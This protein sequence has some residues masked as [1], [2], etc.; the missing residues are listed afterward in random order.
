M[1][2]S[3]HN[4][5][6]NLFNLFIVSILAGLVFGFMR[7]QEAHFLSQLSFNEFEASKH[8]TNTI[9]I[10]I[11]FTILFSIVLIPFYL[12]IKKTKYL[13]IVVFTLLVFINAL[14]IKY[15]LSA[16]DLLGAE[17]FQFSLAEVFYIIS[18]ENNGIDFFNFILLFFYPL[19]FIILSYIFF[20]YAQK[21]ATPIKYFSVA[22]YLVFVVASIVDYKYYF[23]VYSKYDAYR[24]YILNNNKMS[25]F[26]AD[27]YKYYTKTNSK[28]STGAE[29]EKIILNYQN[30]NSQFDYRDIKFPFMHYEAYQN[31]LGSYFETADLKPNVVFILV[32]SL[33]RSFSGPNAYLGSFTPF[34]DSLQKESLYWENFLSNAERTYG[35]LPNTLSSAPFFSGFMANKP[36]PKY[37]SIVKELKNYKYYSS[38]DYGGWINFNSMG[39][40]LIASKIDVIHDEHSFDTTRFKKH[41]ATEEDFHWGYDDEAL[42]KQYFLHLKNIPEPYLSVLLTITMHSPFDVNPNFKLENLKQY[43]Q[44]NLLPTQLELLEKNPE[45]IKAI[46]FSDLQLKNFFENYKKRADFE[47][48]IF[49]LT[50]DHNMQM[51]PLKNELDVFHVP[52]FIYS[53]L[54]KQP[55]TF[56]ALATHR[57]ITPSILGLL[58]G[59]FNMPFQQKKHWLSI[60]LDTASY[61]RSK[62]NTPMSLNSN[63]NISYLKNQHFIFGNEVYHFDSTLNVSLEQN[64]DIKEQLLK[65]KT[66]YIKLE[67]YV[68][69][70]DR[71]YK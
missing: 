17:I 41:K 53:K 31:P 37:N 1:K 12:L 26:I 55:K 65:T 49:I 33:S 62:I 9:F 34:L 23:P 28:E 70:N 36:Y 45:K 22:I 63:K 66:D 21:I 10:D 50:G 18:T 42:L 6:K 20:K 11:K 30:H 8:L 60:G 48:T 58:E 68:K 13:S 64:K 4:F 47:N 40:F 44:N 54:L 57:D 43:Y 38:F 19:F 3:I 39:D 69:L 56:P 7:L 5:I 29:L 32:E 52:L 24:Q 16:Y 61:F 27:S 35:V 51:L 71:L 59:N 67:D 2:N 14:L 46:A 25:Y 15:F